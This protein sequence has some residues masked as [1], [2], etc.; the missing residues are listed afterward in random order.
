[1]N[2]QASKEAIATLDFVMAMPPVGAVLV[3][4]N[5]KVVDKIFTTGNGALSNA[6]STVHAI[7]ALHV[8][9]M[10]MQGNTFVWELIMNMDNNSVS[11][12]GLNGWARE[13]SC[14]SLGTEI[15]VLYLV[16]LLQRSLP[17]TR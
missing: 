10:P 12:S 16:W 9:A 11:R 15:F 2:Y 4:T 8:Q 1:M 3:V 7:V 17:L 5:G 6:N 14:I 13:S